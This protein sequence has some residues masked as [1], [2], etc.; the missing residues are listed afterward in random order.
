MLNA[1]DADL[2]RE[3]RY[4]SKQTIDEVFTIQCT[5]QINL[6]AGIKAENLQLKMIF[7]N[8]IYGKKDT[9]CRASLNYFS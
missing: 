7:L 5:Q 1:Q 6:F 3:K 4:L 2:E 9:C 8:Q